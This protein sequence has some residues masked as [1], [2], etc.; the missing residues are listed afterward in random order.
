MGIYINLEISK[1]V[2]KEEWKRVYEETL[3]LAK[4][5]SLAG[6]RKMKIHDIDIYCLAPVEEFETDDLYSETWRGWGASGDYNYLETAEYFLLPKELV[7]DRIPDPYAGDAMLG[8]DDSCLS[9][10]VTYSLWGRKFQGMPYHIDLLAIAALIETKLGRKAFTYGDIMLD[11]FER[12][13][14]LANEH[15]EQPIE[16]PDCCCADRF[17]SR[18]SNLP[19]SPEERWQVF[20][21]FY[22]GVRNLDFESYKYMFGLREKLFTHETEDQTP[23][24]KFNQLMQEMRKKA[25]E[26]KDEYDIASYA[27]LKVYEKGDRLHPALMKAVGKSRKF[28]DSLLE[29]EEFQRI[30]SLDSRTKCK[31][32]VK[33]NEY[34][35][36]RD[37]EWEKIF[38]EIETDPNAFGRYYKIVRSK[39]TDMDLVEMCVAFFINDEFYRYSGELVKIDS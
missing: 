26:E 27:A 4:K 36:L 25:N 7:G 17:S 29:T 23:W 20:D 5:L 13:V 2:T 34:M 6:S 11:Q 39:L 21:N 16:L 8:V 15:L 33:E 12:A 37:K 18:V 24:L 30:N 32:I 1:S 35:M 31:W 9:M 28:L 10:G 22:L 3:A 38:T 19:L 14:K